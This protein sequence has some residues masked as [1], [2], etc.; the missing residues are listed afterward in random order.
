MYAVV[1]F[2]LALLSPLPFVSPFDSIV[3]DATAQS[4]TNVPFDV[5]SFE[6]IHTLAISPFGVIK[7]GTN[8]FDAIQ[9]PAYIET[10]KID[11]STYAG[12]F[13]TDSDYF[14]IINITDPSS[15][16][17]VSVLDSTVNSTF[18]LTKIDYTVIDG[19]TYLISTSRGD[20]SVL[21]INVSNPL[22][23]YLTCIIRYSQ[24]ILH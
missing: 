20:D 19:S 1:V 16:S 15:P 6:I 22:L 5:P 3:Q 10:F 9:T 13:S 24:S 14:T 4:S 8:G 2:A 21:I 12:I 23:L 17:Q 11:D 7:N 18:N